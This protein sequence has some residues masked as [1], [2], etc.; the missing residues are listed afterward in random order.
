MSL[1]GDQKHFLRGLAHHRR[2]S[3]TVGTS[4]LAE[5]VLQEIRQALQHHELL[6]IKLPAGRR[7]QRQQLAQKICVDTGS[8]LVQIIGRMCV[9]YRRGD[10]PVLALPNH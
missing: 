2:P 4:G 10:D 7:D 8:E 3:V 9:I 6:K 1:T 5:N